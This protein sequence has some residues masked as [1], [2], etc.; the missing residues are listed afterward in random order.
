MPDT[1]IHP[2][3]RKHCQKV[4]T[5]GKGLKGRGVNLKTVPKIV[6]YKDEEQE[7]L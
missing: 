7:S 4:C 1:G 6:A 5:S 3:H 2:T